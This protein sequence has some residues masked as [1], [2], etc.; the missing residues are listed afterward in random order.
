M[1]KVMEKG[2][3]FI[4]LEIKRIKNLLTGKISENKKNELN[5][6]VNILSRFKI[7]RNEEL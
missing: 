6:T 7:N 1:K 2:D 3:G 4:E 5:D